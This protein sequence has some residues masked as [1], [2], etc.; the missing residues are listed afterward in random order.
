MAQICSDGN[1]EYLKT[2]VDEQ[3]AARAYDVR[4][5]EL[6][7]P[8]NFPDHEEDESEGEGENDS[9]GGSDG[10]QAAEGGEDQG[11]AAHTSRF[12]GVSRNGNK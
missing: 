3:E 9:D 2:F 11:P 6:G 12:V 8:T 7:R 5:R 10:R 1:V 4:A